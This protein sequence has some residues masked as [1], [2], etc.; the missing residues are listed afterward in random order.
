[1]DEGVID[2]AA[3][4]LPPNGGIDSIELVSYVR[5]ERRV[6]PRV[7]TTQIEIRGFG[8]IPIGAQMLDGRDIAAP[9]GM[10]Q[11]VRI[12]PENLRGAFQEDFFGT[13][14]NP[15]QCESGIVNAILATDQIL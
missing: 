12:T 9:V 4:R 1:S 2:G 5:P 14:K 15:A 11:L 10:K 7:R 8:D 3:Q 13:G 6:P